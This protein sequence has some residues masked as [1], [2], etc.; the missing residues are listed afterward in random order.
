[1]FFFQIGAQGLA[2]SRNPVFQNWLFP[3]WVTVYCNSLRLG[4]AG[5]NWLC[6]FCEDKARFT[7]STVWLWQ[8]KANKKHP[9]ETSLLPHAE[10]GHKTKERKQPLEEAQGRMLRRISSSSD[11]LILL[12]RQ[13][14][15]PNQHVFSSEDGIIRQLGTE[16]Q[17]KWK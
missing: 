14:I 4:S 8:V 6:L 15:K 16:I 7:L 13:G 3:C 11:E 12:G 17:C 5:A 2:T 1:M 9:F 10:S